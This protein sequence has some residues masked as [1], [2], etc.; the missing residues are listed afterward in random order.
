[1]QEA[2]LWTAWLDEIL[3]QQDPVLKETVEQLA[4]GLGDG[5]GEYADCNQRLLALCLEM[6]PTLW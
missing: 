5:T 6:S 1:M 3:R 4:R 2:G